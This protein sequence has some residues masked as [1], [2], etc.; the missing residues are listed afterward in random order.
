VRELVQ[1]FDKVY[2]ELGVSVTIKINNRKVLYGIAE[3]Y[4]IQDKFMDMTIAMDKLDKIGEAK[5]IEEMIGR[6]IAEAA[7]T[8]VIKVLEIDNLED[9][10]KVFDGKSE[11]GMKGIEELKTFHNYI[12]RSNLTNQLKFDISLARGLN[13]YTGCI[14][15]VAANDVSI[16]SIG[17]GGRYDDLTA[18]FGL[19][20]VSGVGISFGFARIYDVM[21]EL[22][23]FPPSVTKN[24]DLLFVAF[25]EATHTHAFELLSKVRNEGIAADLYPA[26]VKLKKQMKYADDI[27]A[28]YVVLVG[29][30]EQSTGNYT[31]KNMS[32]G[33]QAKASIDELVAKFTA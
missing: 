28:P 21:E 1:L 27:S 5:V 22:N 12:D 26:P 30:E 19:K 8:S 7:A 25:D 15:E 18:V 33:E 6:G 13:Y 9:L 20:G 3:S 14:F 16:G 17:G 2:A 29:S 23:L 10:T 24:I 4:G 11:T 32:T 31:I